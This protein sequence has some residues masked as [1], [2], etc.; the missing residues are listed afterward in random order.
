MKLTKSRLKQIIKEELALTELFGFGKKK[1]E[2][3]QA[4][5]KD[6]QAAALAYI[7]K[8]QGAE[9]GPFLV[10]GSDNPNKSID[11]NWKWKRELHTKKYSEEAS[12]SIAAQAADLQA[13]IGA[14]EQA[15][16]DRADS[17]NA[18]FDIRA[19]SQAEAMPGLQTRA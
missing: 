11:V 2:K 9:I 5:L 10:K 15:T 19:L 12:Q 4:A 3:S 1:K 8:Y 7:D 18:P 17:D 14:W 16:G 6:A 13:I